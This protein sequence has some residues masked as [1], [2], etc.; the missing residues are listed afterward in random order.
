MKP[1]EQQAFHLRPTPPFRLDLTAW[2]LR[3]RRENIIDRWDGSVYRRV[4]VLEGLPVEVE[5]SQSGSP[6]H[7]ALRVTAGAEKFPPR[8]KAALTAALER[9][10][11][12][13]LDLKEFYP[14]GGSHSRLAPLAE[15]FRGV[16]PPRFPTVFE[17]VANGIACQQLSLT[18]G[19]IL[20]NRLAKKYGASVEKPGE[21]SYSFPLPEKIA[22]A[23]ISGLRSLGFSFQ[24]ARALIELARKAVVEGPDLGGLYGMDKE[25]A[26]ERL[27]ELRGVGR[28][29]A[30][31]VLLRGLGRIDIFPGDDVGARNKLQRLL[32]LEK[33]DYDSVAGIMKRWR[34]Y[35]GFIYFHL[36]LD[37]L[38]SAGVLEE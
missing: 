24:K 34:P 4:L 27:Y 33:L 7:P 21:T 16:K 20:L 13:R 37:G 1:L 25:A 10:L 17:T 26:L 32:H 2:A 9:M 28:W 22:Q 18:V 15:R 14:F 31:Y 36:L 3:R 5:V 38:S 30:E 6:E 23:R 8:W 35:G 19:I 11:G 12:L 29:T